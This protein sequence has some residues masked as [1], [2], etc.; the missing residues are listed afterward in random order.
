MYKFI[1]WAE[2]SV[3]PRF[4]SGL[5]HR[6]YPDFVEPDGQLTADGLAFMDKAREVFPF[7]FKETNAKIL[8]ADG[9]RGR[10]GFGDVEGQQDSVRRY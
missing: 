4:L 9:F 8:G 7:M 10:R 1:R 2:W 6:V 5:M 3:K